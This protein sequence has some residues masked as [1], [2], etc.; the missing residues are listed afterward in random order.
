MLE[1]NKIN[2]HHL[3]WWSI[4]CLLGLYIK[5]V[6][7]AASQSAFIKNSRLG[8][9]NMQSNFSISEEK[10]WRSLYTENRILN[11]RFLNGQKA[12]S[13]HSTFVL[14][15]QIVIEA[16]FTDEVLGTPP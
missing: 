8:H 1:Q 7:A 6:I 10:P 13:L 12:Y 3:I 2:Y 9:E 15:M 5:V 11:G 4:G 16:N 14:G